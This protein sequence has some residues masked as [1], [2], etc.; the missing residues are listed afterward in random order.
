MYKNFW[1]AIFLLYALGASAVSMQVSEIIVEGNKRIDRETVLHAAGLHVGQKI[2]T[3]DLNTALKKVFGTGFF[4]DAAIESRHGKVIFK[5]IESATVKEIA[6]EGNKAI[7]DKILKKDSTLHVGMIYDKKNVQYEVQKVLAIY[8]A[9]GYFNAT[10]SPQVVAR[11][12]NRVDIVFEIL[13][14][15]PA[16]I[17][18]INFTGNTHFGDWDLAGVIST[19]ESFWWK[20]FSSDDIY[21]PSR[22]EM[23]KELLRKFYLNHGFIDFKVISA[24]SE[25]IAHSNS[26]VINF[27][28]EEGP[29]YEFGNIKIDA[30]LKGLSPE[31][32]ES[33]IIVTEGA[34]YS[35]EGVEESVEALTQRVSA[36]GYGFVDISPILTINR[37]IHKVDLKFAIQE[38]PKVFV[39]HIIIHGNT[40]TV[41]EVIRRECMLAERDP[42]NASRLRSSERRINALGYFKK[43]KLDDTAAIDKPGWVDVNL[44]VEEQSTG[45]INFSIGYSTTDGPVGMMRLAERNLF[46]RAYELSSTLQLAKRNKQI[47]VDFVNPYLFGRDLAYGVGVFYTKY[48]R[49]DTSSYNECSVGARH[50]IGY[51]LLPHLVERW[52]YSISR[53]NVGTVGKDAF[54]LVQQEKGRFTNSGI[55]HELIYDRRDNRFVATRGYFLTM[56]NQLSGLGGNVRYLKNTLIGA[57]YKTIREHVVLSIDGQIGFIS[58]L[59]KRVRISDKFL[60]GGNNLRGFDYGGVSPHGYG[61]SAG[62]KNKNWNDALGGDVIVNMSAQIN[63]PLGLPEDFS[64]SGHVFIDAGTLWDTKLAQRVKSY[65]AKNATNKIRAYNSKKIRAAAGVGISWA[66]PMGVI[67]IDY[68]VP[69]SKAKGD[70]TRALLFQMGTS[71][72]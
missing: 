56:N 36:L 1:L 25:L 49:D 23:D 45:D 66:S 12:H 70:Q 32:I 41:D 50:W 51:T 6:F 4:L 58:G 65:N 43:V 60:L 3:E 14:G 72:F 67:G 62:N 9:K 13:E 16:K 47:S 53:D 24:S 5:L 48:D 7:T 29:R 55:G 28:L 10:V 59:G 63:F 33:E 44:E 46:G 27:S 42:F 35:A 18:A 17:A 15:T 19:K 61:T 37:N 39:N 54:P 21:D 38:G 31:E 64:V 8:R 34:W 22:I 69:F 68:A 20:F 2:G 30:Q 57:Y 52:S 71:K 26:F 40:R 11:D